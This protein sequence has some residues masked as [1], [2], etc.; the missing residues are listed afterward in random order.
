MFKNKLFLYIIVLFIYS[1]ITLADN[2]PIYSFVDVHIEKEAVNSFKAKELAINEIIKEKFQVLYKNLSVN[3]EKN[4]LKIKNIDYE[5][6][7]KNLVIKNEIVTEKKY[8]ADLELYFNKDKIINFYKQNNI[9]FSDT[10]SPNILIL[11]G[12]NFDGSDILWEKNNWNFLWNDY[13]KL[14]NQ[15]ILTTPNIE[16]I[17]KILISPID[18]FKLNLVNIEKILNHYNLDQS[19]IITASKKYDTEDSKIYINL[20]ITY[21]NKKNQSLE[22]ILSENILIDNFDNNNLLTDLTD[23]SYY[24][25]FD[26]WKNKTITHFNKK[27]HLVCSLNEMNIESV[28][29][30]KDKLISI[31]HVNKILLNSI[32]SDNVKLNIHYYGNLDEIKDIFKLYNIII[33]FKSNECFLTHES[34]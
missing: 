12:Y 30:I 16:N 8:I 4:E 17:N 32:R 11:S 23:Y 14:N 7:L 28:N 2:N 18:I 31:S 1:S 26:W 22:K 6:F 13:T 5:I 15:L 21:Y 33:Y 3:K 10:L 9:L 27:N 19:I 24:N 34:I 25:I 20:L 29:K